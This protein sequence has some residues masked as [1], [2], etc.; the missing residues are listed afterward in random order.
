MWT[1]FVPYEAAGINRI[2]IINQSATRPRPS[3]YEGGPMTIFG[4]V[5]MGV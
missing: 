4:F 3:V 2:D 1:T 5:L